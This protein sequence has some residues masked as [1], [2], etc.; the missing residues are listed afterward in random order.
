MESGTLNLLWA[1]CVLGKTRTK[2]ANFCPQK[3]HILSFLWQQ[4]VETLT[5]RHKKWEVL[6]LNLLGL[7]SHLLRT[8]SHLLRPVLL[9][10]FK[11]S[12]INIYIE[13]DLTLL[14]TASHLLGLLGWHLEIREWPLYKTPIWTQTKTWHCREKYNFC[15]FLTRILWPCCPCTVPAWTPLVRSGPP[16]AGAPSLTYIPPSLPPLHPPTPNNLGGDKKN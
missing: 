3:C 4:V 13:A 12:L 8:T 7:A 14:R 5:S 2:A 11:V 1:R 16:V 6:A 15:T 9:T 10:N